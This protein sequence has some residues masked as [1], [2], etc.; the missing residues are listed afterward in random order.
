M[1]EWGQKLHVRLQRSFHHEPFSPHL[2]PLNFFISF[3]KETFFHSLLAQLETA[4]RTVFLFYDAEYLHLFQPHCGLIWPN[5]NN[6]KTEHILSGNP[7][8]SRPGFTNWVHPY[9]FIQIVRIQL[10]SF[11]IATNSKSETPLRSLKA[12]VDTTGRS[13]QISHFKDNKLVQV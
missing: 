7:R 11:K 6:V 8:N 10:E 2:F 4:I 12:E 1:H 3:P 13:I 9:E 5:N